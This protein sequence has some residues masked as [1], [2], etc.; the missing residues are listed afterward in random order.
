MK[1]DGVHFRAIEN[2][3]AVEEYVRYAFRIPPWD[4]GVARH[5]F[6]TPSPVILEAAV[7]FLDEILIS[8]SV[9][10]GFISMFHLLRFNLLMESRG[11]L[12]ET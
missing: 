1:E 12:R 8:S 3:L 5:N 4:S 11:R 10:K 7:I 6:V 9:R 2:R